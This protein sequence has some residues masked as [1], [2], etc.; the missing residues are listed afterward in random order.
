MDFTGFSSF[1]GLVNTVILLF[2]LYLIIKNRGNFKP[3]V[4]QTFDLLAGALVLA[5]FWG[6]SSMAGDMGVM[7][8]QI[9]SLLSKLFATLLMLVLM[10]AIWR[11]VNSVKGCEI[12]LF[13]KEMK[14]SKKR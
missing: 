11:L 12:P 6:L 14:K 4:G 1:L 8:A 5:L 9:S 2:G 13:P 7:D 10:V 3:S